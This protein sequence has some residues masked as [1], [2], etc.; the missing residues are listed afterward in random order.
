LI[1]TVNN[2]N[3]TNQKTDINISGMTCSGCANT[4]EKALAKLDGVESASVDHEKKSA[5]VIYDANKV[6]SADFERAVESS[7]YTFEGDK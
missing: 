3:S 1:L 4:V 5:S 7:G 6:T 2:M